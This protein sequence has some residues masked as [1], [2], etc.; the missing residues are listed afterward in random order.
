MYLLNTSVITRTF[1]KPPWEGSNSV[2]SMATISFGRDANKCP[3]KLPGVGLV[4]FATWQRSH[5]WT[6]RLMSDVIPGQ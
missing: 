6:H 1:S 5:P 3:M 4:S 2:K